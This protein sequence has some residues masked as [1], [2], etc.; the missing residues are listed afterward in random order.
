[1]V[2]ELQRSPSGKVDMHRL[3]Q[4]L[5]EGRPALVD[6]ALGDPGPTDPAGA[7]DADPAAVDPVPADPAPAE[8]APDPAPHPAES[9]R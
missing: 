1:M 4:R 2:D 7:G 5:A 6:T 8:P 3:R 9:T